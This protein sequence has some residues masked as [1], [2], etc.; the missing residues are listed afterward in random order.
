MYLIEKIQFKHYSDFQC[1]INTLRAKRYFIIQILEF[2]DADINDTGK[3][4]ILFEQ[5]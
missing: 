3:A 5:K 2:K 4:T 1:Q